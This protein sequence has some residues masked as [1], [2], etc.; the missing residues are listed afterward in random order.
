MILKA[1]TPTTS[2]RGT[3]TS[4]IIS[5]TFDA[6]PNYCVRFWYTLYGN[7]VKNFNV[8]IKVQYHSLESIL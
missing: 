1:S 7:D 2:S 6:A 5:P 3:K 4:R 8:Y